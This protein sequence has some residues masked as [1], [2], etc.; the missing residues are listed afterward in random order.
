M[1]ALLLQNGPAAPSKSGT[2]T[3]AAPL[4][5]ATG[6]ALRHKLEQTGGV[7]VVFADR[8][9]P[10]RLG[11]IISGASCQLLPILYVL[12]EG[13][14]SSRIRSSGNKSSGIKSSRISGAVPAIRVDSLD[15]VAVYR[16]AHEAIQRARQGDGPT[17]M[18]CATW[19]GDSETDS[20]QKLERYLAG[21]KLFRRAWKNRLEEE[22]AKA[23]G[24]FGKTP[25]PEL[26]EGE[27]GCAPVYT[28]RRNAV[29]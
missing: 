3:S 9:E 18:E 6:E 17:V 12:N 26:N 8:G 7:T 4:A 24:D 10:E 15:T 27:M 29:A 22:Y 5:A 21:K 23:L 25:I 20:L 14:Q 2:L 16:V 11:E 19:P 13:L 28:R 1:L